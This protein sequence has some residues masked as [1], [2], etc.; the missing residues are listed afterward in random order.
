MILTILITIII[1]SFY[2]YKKHIYIIE[3]GNIIFKNLN[4][5]HNLETLIKDLIKKKVDDITKI[6]KAYYFLGSLKIVNNKP[7]ILISNGKIDYELL[8]KI[9]KTPFFILKALKKKSLKINQILY[10]VYL[11]DILYIV[12]S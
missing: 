5:N 7:C 8:F 3:N 12:K 11:N 1:L 4:D 6:E 9:K 10:A 2:E